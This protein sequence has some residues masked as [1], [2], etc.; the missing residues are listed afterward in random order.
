MPEAAATDRE[1]HIARFLSANGWGKAARGR[2]AGDASFR[3]YDRL[4]LGGKRAVLMDAPPPVE[5]VRP[6][7]A[8]AE[9]LRNMG[10]SAP[11]SSR[12]T[13]STACCCWRTSATTPTPACSRAATTRPSSTASPST[14]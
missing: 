10:Y 3:H 1:A 12:P 8:V 11:A 5:D 9:L 4:E 2:L 7:A 6:Y 13:P 14:S